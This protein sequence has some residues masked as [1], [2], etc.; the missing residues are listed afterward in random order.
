MAVSL[1]GVRQQLNNRQKAAVLLIA[2]GPEL[3][4][5]VLK[6]LN[7]TEI[8]QLTLE[9]ASLRQVPAEVQN[10]VLEE[11]E[12][13]AMARQYIA[14]GGI[15][16]ARGL[17]EKALGEDAASDLLERLTSSLQV[18]PFE[19]IRQA[20][21]SHLLNYIQNEHP[22][23]IALVLAYLPPDQAA[24]IL[25]ALPPEDQAEV[26]RRIAIMDRTAPDIVAEVE[27][28][29][30][31]KLS[32]VVTQDFS[33]AGGIEALVQVLNNVDRSTERGIMD[34]LEINDPELA[35][36]IKKR[37]FVFEDL[38]MLDNRSIQ[39]LL[40]EVD[41][42]EDLPLALKVASDAVKAKIMQNISKRAAETL[43]ENMEYL[44]PVRLRAVE[45]AQQRIVALVR[46][47]EEEGEIE[48]VRGQGDELVV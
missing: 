1:Q 28:M 13:L 29:L 38:V 46:R 45:E 11:F 19:F 48:V 16:Y 44:G 5:K 31:R 15:E 9:I 17:L 26:A 18:R 8:E 35:E 37:M 30:E 25:S 10:L 40:R 14:Q 33:M 20:D 12:Q 7:Q 6:H 39:R 42:N 24:A 34:V 41:M 27:T 23:T 47:L 36:E 4:A 32:S 22:Q 43:E 2:L 3:S 21:P